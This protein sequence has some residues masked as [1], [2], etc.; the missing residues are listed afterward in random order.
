MLKNKNFDSFN[1]I[2]STRLNFPKKSYI[3]KISPLL[4]GGYEIDIYNASKLAGE[5]L[6]TQSNISN[7]KVTRICHVVNPNDKKEENFLSEICGQAKRGEIVL[8]SSLDTKKNY[9][10]IDDLSFLLQRIGPFGKKKFYNIGSNNLIS[11]NEIIKKLIKITKC[12]V[13]T[14]KNAQTILESKINISILKKEFNYQ[15]THKK[16]WLEKALKKLSR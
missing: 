2:S 8:N 6:C 13:I 9:I 14:S 4:Y 7:V 11:N 5:A 1:Y 15:P 10:Q 3:N 16:L 12:S